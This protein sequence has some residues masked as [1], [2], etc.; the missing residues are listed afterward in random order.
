MD[1]DFAM[2]QKLINSSNKEEGVFARFYT[3]AVKTEELGENGLPKFKNVEYIEIRIRD[4]NDIIKRKADNNDKERFPVEYQRY[5]L[6]KKQVEKG[7]PLNQFA[8]LDASQLETCKYRGIFTVETLASLDDEKAKSIDL[9]KE[10]DLAKKFIEVSKNNQVIDD[11]SKKEKKYKEEI[12][13]LKEEIER[14]K[15]AE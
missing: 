10:R 11:F 1:A 3:K 7:T 12:K 14:L 4:N 8:F 2:F 9:L 5:L 13:R 6:E 15:G